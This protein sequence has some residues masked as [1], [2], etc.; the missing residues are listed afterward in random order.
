M[1]RKELTEEILNKFIMDNIIYVEYAEGGAMGNTGGLIIYIIE[2]DD[3]VHYETNVYNNAELYKKARLKIERQSNGLFNRN[4]KYP[5]IFDYHYG[6]FGNHTFLNINFNIGRTE[7]S[8]LFKKGNDS[9]EVRSS[10]KGVFEHIV[11]SI[12]QKANEKFIKDINTQLV[13]L[14]INKIE[15]LS[16]WMERKADELEASF[17]ALN[18]DSDFLIEKN[19]NKLKK[20]NDMIDKHDPMGLIKI[21]NIKDQ[22]QSEA[23]III[24]QLKENQT[25][26]DVQAIVYQEFKTIYGSKLAGSKNKY[27]ELARDIQRWIIN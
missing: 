26:E 21:I 17:K 13:A 8:L 23:E 20:L 4:H 12:K 24:S 3:S 9:F 7:D 22:Y 16:E 5:I 15:S 14:G 27:F 6:G 19:D 25:I 1:Y 10:N 18:D 11:G 2:N